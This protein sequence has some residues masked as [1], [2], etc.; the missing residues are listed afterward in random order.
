MDEALADLFPVHENPGQDIFFPV[1]EYRAR[2]L[3]YPVCAL[4]TVNGAAP[5]MTQLQ[6]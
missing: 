4:F 2:R 3:V 6:E 1:M 5:T